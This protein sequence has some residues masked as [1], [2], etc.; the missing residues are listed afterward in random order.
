MVAPVFA[1]L[2]VNVGTGRGEQPLPGPLAGEG[3]IANRPVFVPDGTRAFI[4]GAVTRTSSNST[5][6][7]NEPTAILPAVN[8]VSVAVS[9]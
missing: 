1:G 9:I 4:Q 7:S 5:G 3:G 8:D 6:M 2:R